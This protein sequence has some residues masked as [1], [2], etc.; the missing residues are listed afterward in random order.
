MYLAI[1]MDLEGRERS[2]VADRGLLECGLR[3]TTTGVERCECEE[4][5]GPSTL[6]AQRE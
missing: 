5:S 3:T 2:S 6:E 1:V 4:V